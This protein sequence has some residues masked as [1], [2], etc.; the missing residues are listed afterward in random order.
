MRS[1]CEEEGLFVFVLFVCG[2][3]ISQSTAH[4]FP[5]SLGTSRKPFA[6]YGCIKLVS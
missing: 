5:L 3:E 2:V 4:L 1:I 6:E